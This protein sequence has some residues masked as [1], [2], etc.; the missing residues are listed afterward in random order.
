MAAC[1]CSAQ[2]YRPAPIHPQASAAELESRKL[3]DAGLREYLAK[4]LTHEISPWPAK[5]WD[6]NML[7]LAAFYFSSELDAA[8]ERVLE[9]EAATVTAGARPN[10]NFRVA[11]GIPSPYLLSLDFMV[12]IETAGKRGYRIAAARSLS[13]AARFDLANTGWMVRDRVRGAMLNALLASRQWELFRS[14]EEILAKQV[15]LLE[16]R[17]SAGEIAQPEANLARIQLQRNRVFMQTAEGQMATTRAGVAAAIGVPVAGLG[18]AEFSWPELESLPKA[19][20]LSAGEIQRDATVNRLDVRRALAQYAAAEAALQLEI[21]KQYPDLNIGPGYAYEE[22][23]NF[24]TIGLSATLPLFNRNQGPIG[25]AEARR[26]EAAT[27]FV[28]TQAQVIAQSEAALANYRSAYQ[29]FAAADE[30][31]RKLQQ[32]QQQMME[33]AIREGEQDR[34]AL[35]GVQLESA[36]VARARLDALSRAQSS[37]GALENAVQRPLEP[38]EVV[39][40]AAMIAHSARAKGGT[41]Q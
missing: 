17:V 21:A 7:T 24:F 5:Q 41:P 27:A 8:R 23:N 18:D 29:E 16:R 10:P 9:A 33:T 31:L 32:N 38:A 26:R 22:T 4:N 40:T 1:G 12:P 25:E 13:E 34:L 3:S 19:D 6:L 35:I 28:A 2:H 11:P 20:S 37:L 36:V 39:P 15:H 30:S 14:Q